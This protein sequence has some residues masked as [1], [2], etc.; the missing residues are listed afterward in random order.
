MKQRGAVAIRE[1]SAAR[2]LGLYTIAKHT[3]DDPNHALY[4]NEAV[5]LDSPNDFSDAVKLTSVCLDSKADSIYPAYGFLSESSEFCEMLK[6]ADILFVGPS[7][8]ILRNVSEKTKA[9]HVAKTNH[10]PVLSALSEAIANFDEALP[11]VEDIGF[12]LMIKA[13]DGGGGRGIR[14]IHGHEDL[15]QGFARACGESPSGRVFLE[16]AA[17]D[18]YG[19]VEVQILGD[20]YGEV[21]HFWERECSIQR[22]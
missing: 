15:K 22:R 21:R 7:P 6:E 1:L 13:V 18:G 17:V 19:H 20:Q 5:V 10:V 4:A 8:A 14:L 2:E 12:P 11:F 3:T 9:R 16:R